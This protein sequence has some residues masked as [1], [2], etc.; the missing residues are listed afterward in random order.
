MWFGDDDE[1]SESDDEY[2]V[3]YRKPPKHSRF[4]KGQSG[5]SR[6]KPRGTKNSAT[7][8]K[9]ALLE[10]VVVKQSGRQSKTTK[11]RVIAAQI[12]NKAMKGDYISIR[13]LLR[14]VRLDRQLNRPESEHR[15]LSEQS[16][17]IIRRALLG[18]DYEPEISNQYKSN[19]TSPPS[20]STAIESRAG[21][22]NQKQ[23]YRVGYRKPP[24]HTRFKK[25]RSGNPAGRPRVARSFG[26]L[27][28]QLLDE[29]VSVT[30]NGREQVVS[31]LQV[32]FTQIV[33]QAALGD[34]RFQAL[35]LEFTPT[36]EITLRRRRLSKN[37]VELVRRSLFADI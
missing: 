18:D 26:M 5:N 25:G 33:N 19:E 28:R 13:L 2:E 9:Q 31:R 30:E 15:G 12:V 4:G 29:E 32:I 11:F 27:F 3:G 24:L 1:G 21:A 23:A 35:L 17:R 14:S 8:L 6:G 36:M 7:L 37:A 20:T 16:V 34:P 10:S 22:A